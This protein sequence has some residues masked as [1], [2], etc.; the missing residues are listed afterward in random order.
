[1]K[2]S[3]KLL[4]ILFAFALLG[5][6]PEAKADTPL[7]NKCDQKWGPD[8]VKT[9]Q[10]ISVYREFFKQKNYDAAM[11]TWRSV[12]NDAPCARETTHMDGITM[13][14][15][16]LT[17]EKNKERRTQIIDTIFMI[18]D[19]RS[20]NFPENAGSI[21]GR[22]AVDMLNYTPEPNINVLNTFKRSIKLG[23]NNTE[24]FVMPYYFKVALKEFS[25]GQ[26]TKEQVIEIYESMDKIIQY[27]ITAENNVDK[28]LEA[29]QSLD[30]DLAG[31]IIKDCDEITALFEAKFKADPANKEL[32]DLLFSLLLSKGC[33]NKELFV[34]VAESKYTESP[35]A[36]LALVLGRK[37]KDS[38]MS[39]SVKYYEAAISRADNDST[40]AAYTFELA[41][42]YSSNNQFSKARQT[43]MDA[44]RLLPR[45]GKPYLF[46]GDLYA[47]SSRQCGSGIESQSVFWAAIDKYQYAKSIDPSV[48]EEANKKIGQYSGYFPRSEDL[49]FNNIAKGSSYKVGCWIGETTTV[50]SSD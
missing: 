28:Y 34:T 42:V 13:Y 8:S 41:S 18:Y 17:T 50:R 7:K 21:V 1:M 6:A 36:T 47:S 12:F 29:K 19:V 9:I 49:F 35:S 3:V 2:I 26:L 27:N 20:A 4:S 30:A 39:Q 31:N 40:K 22:K 32:R 46:I 48:A 23:G 15:A 33:T 43:A 38:D 24:Y 11:E 25:A 14:K 5:T 37:Y 45:W 10:N 44:A 16:K